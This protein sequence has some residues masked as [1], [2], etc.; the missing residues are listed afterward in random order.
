[1]TKTRRGTLSLL[2]S[3]TLF[4][5][6]LC[7]PV[8]V[9]GQQT[10]EK[11]ERVYTGEGVVIHINVSSVKFEPDRILRAQYRTALSKAETLRGT[12]SA[13][14]KSRLETI[15]FKLN[16]GRYRFSDITLL[17]PDSRVLHS[18]TMTVPGDW[19]I[20]KAGGV[21]ERLFQAACLYSL[22]GNWKTVAY[23][24]PEGTPGGTTPHAERLIGTKVRLYSDAAEVGVRVCDSPAYESKRAARDE[25][26][27]DLGI[28]VKALGIKGEYVETIN[29]K[30]E[31]SGWQPPSS[32]LLKISDGEMLMLWDGVFLVLKI[33]APSFTHG[34]PTQPTQLKRRP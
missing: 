20:I 31:G 29:I 15:D 6:V 19:R 23:R 34:F 3:V 28:D 16:E 11:W 9:Q 33:D 27:R 21:T 24:W 18:Y 17:D 4:A 26:L 1:M 30:C 2:G 8:R 7:G 22:F 5:C 25:L 13:K 32:L 12:P 10:T 14:Y